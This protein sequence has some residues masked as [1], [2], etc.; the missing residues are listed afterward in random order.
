MQ[1]RKKKNI[2]VTTDFAPPEAREAGPAIAVPDSF[3]EAVE[4]IVGAVGAGLDV[5]EIRAMAVH[6]IGSPTLQVL[7]QLEMQKSRNERKRS[8]GGGEEVTLLGKLAGIGAGGEGGEEEGEEEEEGGKRLSGFFANLLYDPVGSHLAEKIMSYAP[9]REFKKLYKAH[10]RTRMGSLAR[11]ETAGFVV[12]RVLEKLGKDTMKEAIGE[13]L[14][15]VGG[16]IG[17]FEILFILF[18]LFTDGMR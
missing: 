14:K 4:R 9:K 16:M 2:S 13:I 8:G 6:P 12:V 3:T 5:E 1:S 11:N 17:E 18:F 10:F 15:E 7:L